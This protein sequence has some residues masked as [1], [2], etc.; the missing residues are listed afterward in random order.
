MKTSFCQRRSFPGN[1]QSGVWLAAVS[2]GLLLAPGTSSARGDE[3]CRLASPDGKI[4]ISIRMPRQGSNERP[5]WSATFRGKLLLTDCEL[6]LQTAEAGDLLTG[7]RVLRQHS[8]SADRRIRV[9]FGRADHAQDCFRETRFTLET[10]SHHQLDVVF[11]CYDDAIAL[12]YELPG[13]PKDGLATITDETTSFRVAGAP[14]AYAQ[15]LESYTTSHEHNVT[16][17]N[18]RD[19]Q[20]GTLLDLPLTFSWDD[21]TYLAL[22]EASLRHYAGMSLMRIA[23]DDSPPRLVCKLTP[24]PDGIK[25]VRPSPMLTPWRVALIGD[26]PG[27]LLESETLYCLNDASVIKDVSWIKPGKIT[28]P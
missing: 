11:R 14:T 28:F 10:P 2:A 26:R 16:N 21:G 15:Y 12:R 8:R 20:P 27:A 3:V 25:V 6:G 7:V 22:T 13:K 24:R 9:L 17:V 4:E 18:C 5:I 23:G 19:L 1:L